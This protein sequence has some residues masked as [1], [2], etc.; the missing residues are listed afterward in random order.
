M[1]VRMANTTE[2]LELQASAY[3]AVGAMNRRHFYGLLPGSA[4]F[5]EL[6]IGMHH[7]ER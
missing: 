3:L 7:D 2:L 6:A 1:L 4:S 5:R